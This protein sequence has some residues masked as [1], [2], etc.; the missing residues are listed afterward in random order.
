MTSFNVTLRVL[1]SE[2]RTVVD[3]PDEASA[4]VAAREQVLAGKVAPSRPAEL[5]VVERVEAA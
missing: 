5:L 3:A 4:A 2:F 1:R